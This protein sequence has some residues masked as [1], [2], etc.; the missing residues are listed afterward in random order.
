VDEA[1]GV[2]GAVDEV[3]GGFV[4]P[5]GAGPEVCVGAEG[6]PVGV[7]L[8]ETSVTAGVGRAEGFPGAGPVV[9][10]TGPR[11]SSVVSRKA[12]E[13]FSQTAVTSTA[14]LDPSEKTTSSRCC[15]VDEIRARQPLSG[16]A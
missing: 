9:A 8:F 10:G 7:G 14:R 12:G 15:A 6:R 4:V 3:E 13:P 16:S 1:D 2:E 11:G 5:E